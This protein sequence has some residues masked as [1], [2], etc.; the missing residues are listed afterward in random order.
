MA[1]G[2]GAFAPEGEELVA[3]GYAKI[4]KNPADQD[5]GEG[6]K[7]H[8][9]GIDGPFF[10]DDAGVQDYEPRHRLEAD[11]RRRRHLPRVVAVVQPY[12]GAARPA[13]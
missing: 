3:E 9:G 5:G 1:E 2:R 4:D 10:L 11:E 6:V 8:E 13:G 12:R 7:R